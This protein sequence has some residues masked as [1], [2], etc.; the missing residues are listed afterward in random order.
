MKKLLILLAVAGMLMP[1]CN[2]NIQKED[3]SELPNNSSTINPLANIECQ[4]NEILYTTMYDFPIILN[5]D[6][7]FGAVLM[8]NTYE[9]GIGRL[10]FDYDITTIPKEAFKDCL[11]L[12]CIKISNS[13]TSIGS[14]AFYGCSS[15]KSVIIGNNTTSINSSAFRDCTSLKNIVIPNSVTSISGSTF[16][17]CT[18]LENITIPNS[19]T[20]I[21]STAFRDCI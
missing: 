8:Q 16:Y 9:G 17:G 7:G 20:S 1:A 2:G 4:N 14:S 13:I 10:V 3:S 5:S 18:S 21:G 11:P 19:V 12:V 15:L 6:S